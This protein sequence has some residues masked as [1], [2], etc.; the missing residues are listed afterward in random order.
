M[1]VPQKRLIKE[2]IYCGSY[3]FE[4]KDYP[5]SK[6]KLMKITGKVNFYV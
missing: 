1:N 3:S 5:G 2:M 4:A 6:E